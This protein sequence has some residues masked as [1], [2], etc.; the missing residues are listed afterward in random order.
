MENQPI[1]NIGLIGHVSNGKSSIVKS[2]TKISTHKHS[3]EQKANKTIRLGYAN[4]KIYKCNKCNPPEC[5]DCG[6]SNEFIKKCLIC[7]ND[8]ELINHISFVDC[9]GHTEYMMTMLNGTSIMDTT[10]LVVNINNKN[11]P[12][13]QTLNHI[14]AITMGNIP[15]SLICLNKFDLI[16]KNKVQKNIKTLQ[17]KIKHTVVEKS[18]MI[19]ISA[20]LNINIDVLCEYLSKLKPLHKSID[21]NICKMIIVRSFNINKPG[22]PIE[23][24]KGGIIGGTI[25]KGKLCVGDKIE[26]R[27]GH[28]IKSTIDDS[29]EFKPIIGTVLSLKSD[30]NNLDYAISGG[31]IAVQLDIDPALTTNDGLIGQLLTLK[32]NNLDVYE[33]ISVT[34]EIL[35]KDIQFKKNDTIICNINACNIKAKITKMYK[36]NNKF[37][38]S[39]IEKPIPLNIGDYIIISKNENNNFIRGKVI[40]GLICNEIE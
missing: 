38:C 13:A 2:L 26:L 3:K 4:C 19:P 8:M 18:P 33:K 7:N 9:P 5:Y 36:N 16:D 15:N 29:W 21:D 12:A 30:E 24:L 10:I 22:I 25:L 32:D 17:E 39:F 28:Y 20:T 14:D 1:I 40:N 6:K 34:Y 27:P 31:L 35:N 11:L 37:L 23:N